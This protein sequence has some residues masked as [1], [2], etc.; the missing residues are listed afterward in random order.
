MDIEASRNPVLVSG[1]R[2]LARFNARHPWSHNEYFHDWI[3]ALLAPGGRLLV[4]GLARPDSLTDLA[5]DLA[6][7]VANPVMELIKHLH[8]ARRQGQSLG[9]QPAVPLKDPTATFAEIATAARARLPGVRVQ[10]GL[11]FRYTLRWDKPR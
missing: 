10:R 3:P 7:G 5:F 9:G 8:P 1:L 4:V 6:S 11:F 2:L